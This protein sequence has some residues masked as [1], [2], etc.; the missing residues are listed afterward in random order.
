MTDNNM[1]YRFSYDRILDITNVF[2]HGKVGDYCLTMPGCVNENN[3]EEKVKEQEER[4]KK[5]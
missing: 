5:K 2:Y 3:Y 4:R 1:P